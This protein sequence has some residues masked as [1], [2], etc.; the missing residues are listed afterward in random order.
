VIVFGST[1]RKSVDRETLE[2]L[3]FGLQYL[4]QRRIVGSIELIRK[5]AVLLSK[6]DHVEVSFHISKVMENG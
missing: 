5:W 3:E 1:E 2:G 4:G 6:S